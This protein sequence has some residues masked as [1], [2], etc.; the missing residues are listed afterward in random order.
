MGQAC[1]KVRARKGSLGPFTCGE[2]GTTSISFVPPNN[3]LTT[4]FSAVPN[5]GVFKVDESNEGVD[6]VEGKGM[7]M[8]WQG[9]APALVRAPICSGR[10]PG[11][12]IVT[13]FRI[14]LRF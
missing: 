11:V 2:G 3:V 14:A 6:A 4:R 12:N 8:G 1:E 7:E 10:T 13:T 9:F 5:K